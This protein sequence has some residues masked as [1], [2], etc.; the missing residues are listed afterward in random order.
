M[1]NC[2]DARNRDTCCD[3]AD[4][5]DTKGCRGKVMGPGDCSCMDEVANLA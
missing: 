2:S 5:E 4:L 3:Q 1:F